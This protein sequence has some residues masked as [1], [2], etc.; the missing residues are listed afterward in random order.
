MSYARSPRF[1]VLWIYFKHSIPKR[2]DI[3]HI[4]KPK[5]VIKD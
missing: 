5:D 4:N 1:V 3:S 2:V